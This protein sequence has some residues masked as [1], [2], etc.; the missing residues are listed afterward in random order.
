V[1]RDEGHRCPP[2]LCEAQLISQAQQVRRLGSSS[3][4]GQPQQLSYQAGLT[5]L[6]QPAQQQAVSKQQ[7]GKG[8]FDYVEVVRH[9]SGAVGVSDHLMA[10]TV[11]LEENMRTPCDVQQSS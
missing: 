9:S 1:L 7:S 2:Q 4:K 10:S 8:G 5:Q 3:S 11:L 6:N